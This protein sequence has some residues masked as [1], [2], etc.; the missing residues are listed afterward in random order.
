MTSS[1][2]DR[3]LFVVAACLG[4]LR[5]RSALCP[6]GRSARIGQ[7]RPCH[8]MH[9]T[10][11]ADLLCCKTPPQQNCPRNVERG[12]R[13]TCLGK[14]CLRM[15]RFAG[16][17]YGDLSPSGEEAS[18]NTISPYQSPASDRKDGISPFAARVTPTIHTAKR[19]AGRRGLE[20]RRAP[21]SIVCIVPVMKVGRKARFGRV[22]RYV[23]PPQPCTP[24]P[25]Q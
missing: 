7:T 13:D 18:F 8:T 23:F 6:L 14:Y 1:P 16:L 11:I 24:P 10:T 25:S 4:W 15:G 19:W 22:G 12:S 17:Y 20:A 3:A 5:R 2:P 9:L 21:R